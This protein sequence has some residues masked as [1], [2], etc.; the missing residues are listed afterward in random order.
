MHTIF[1]VSVSVPVFVSVGVSLAV[2]ECLA[3]LPLSLSIFYICVRICLHICLRVCLAYVCMRLRVCVHVCLWLCVYVYVRTSESERACA[4]GRLLDGCRSAYQ[5]TRHN[6]ICCCASTYMCGRV[7]GVC[8]LVALRGGT[9][10]E[11]RWSAPLLP[12][13]A[14]DTGRVGDSRNLRGGQG[15]GEDRQVENAAGEEEHEGHDMV[16]VLSQDESQDMGGADDTAVDLGYDVAAVAARLR[17]VSDN[18]VVSLCM[19]RTKQPR[20]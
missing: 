5:Q 8:Q 11:V 15:Q 16:D 4:C 7:C 1:L 3:R 2:S 20:K 14:E 9:S 18:N 13:A 6:L 19:Q 12:S 10:D 17:S